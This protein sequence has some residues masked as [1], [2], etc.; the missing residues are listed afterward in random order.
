[1]TTQE[2]TAR[3]EE[4]RGELRGERISYGELAELQGLADH[5]ADDDVELLEPA[6]VPEGSRDQIIKI[7]LPFS[8]FYETWHDTRIDEALENYFNYD[9]ESGND[10]EPT[11]AESNAIWSADVDWS[12]IRHEYC[13]EFT[14]GFATEFDIPSL[15]FDELI[16][17]RE[18]NFSTDRLFATIRGDHLD[19][20]RR[21]V[22]SDDTWSETVRERFTSYD[23]FSSFYSAD[24]NDDIWT[25]EVL[26]E[27]QYEVMLQ[28]WIDAKHRD[29]PNNNR[30]WNDLEFDIGAELQVG[31]FES[32]NTAYDKIME[33][34]KETK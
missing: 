26:D 14:E 5:I 9:Y 1:M 25:R 18:Y 7:Q 31:E 19:R 27:C 23:G 4:L 32:V 15:K 34:M 24:I 22:E 10:R 33:Y 11:E 28:H 13:M 30:E 20:I 12:A 16:S 21:E 2:I 6:G 29:D 8:G 17:P 3:L